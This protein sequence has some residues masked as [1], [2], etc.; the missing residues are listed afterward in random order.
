MR[1]PDP[2]L[3]GSTDRGAY[4]RSTGRVDFIPGPHGQSLQREPGSR[5]LRAVLRLGVEDGTLPKLPFKIGMLR[6]TPR[7]I[8]LLVSA[9]VV[10]GVNVSGTYAA[11]AKYLPQWRIN[12]R[13]PEQVPGNWNTLVEKS[14]NAGPIS[15][16]VDTE[17]EI[18]FRVFSI[19]PNDVPSLLPPTSTQA[20]IIGNVAG[21][22]NLTATA[23][24]TDDIAGANSALLFSWMAPEGVI[25]A[26]WVV[27]W[28][29]DGGKKLLPGSRP[30]KRAVSG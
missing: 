13:D 18:D 30:R 19:S 2:L 21:P 1:T 15:L 29:K 10:P 24:H 22:T 27:R 16:P 25:I 20:S 7:D 28:S 8:V 26:G 9:V 5:I 23:T 11:T 3:R 12:A 6:S 17:N 14:A 4:V